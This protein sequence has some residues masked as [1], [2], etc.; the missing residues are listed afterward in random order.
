[1]ALDLYVFILPNL[2]SGAREAQLTDVLID[3]KVI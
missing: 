1:M 3:G 2:A